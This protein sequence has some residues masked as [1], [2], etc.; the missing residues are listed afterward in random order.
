MAVSVSALVSFERKT[1]DDQ[2]SF[3]ESY[4]PIWMAA[5]EQALL[6]A[7]AMPEE[8]YSYRPTDVSKTFAE[9]M[10]HIG[11]TSL[12]VTELFI[13]EEQKA[14][15]EPKAAGMNKQQIIDMIENNFNAAAEIIRNTSD[16][17]AQVNSFTG[18]TFSKMQAINSVQDHLTNHRA[19]AN[20]YVRMNGEEPPA[21]GYY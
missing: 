15:A 20:L 13:A 21:Y 18:K 6:V 3:S 16:W 1:S 11:Y 9:Q 5:K 7:R 8:K 17:D 12:W 14:Y 10:I 2:S 4:L 19:K